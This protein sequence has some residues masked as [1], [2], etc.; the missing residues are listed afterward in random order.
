M[1][2]LG[3]HI[4]A[5]QKLLYELNNGSLLTELI[6]DLKKWK[7]QYLTWFGR[8]SAIKMS[9][10]PKLIYTLYTVPIK[11]PETLFRQI[12]R[13]FVAFVWNDK[14][15]RLAYDILRRNKA[16]RGLGLPDIALNYKAMTLVRI[17]N[18]CHD[19]QNK[20]WV[21]VEKSMTGRNLA[22]AH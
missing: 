12:R 14:R 15:P 10:L 2:Y 3:V 11:I 1:V 16:E 19:A 8:I 5:D 9:I 17:L 22:G 18:W 6:E 4:S 21:Q 7:G 20:L 13:L